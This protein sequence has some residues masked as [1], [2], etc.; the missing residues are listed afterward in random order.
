M[1]GTFCSLEKQPKEEAVI[2]TA[3][4][5]PEQDLGGGLSQGGSAVVFATA[6][7]PAPPSALSAAE[8]LGPCHIS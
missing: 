5:L 4:P 3:C 2:E 8:S 1:I 6:G 7:A